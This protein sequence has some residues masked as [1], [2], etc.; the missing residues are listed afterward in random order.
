MD[1]HHDEPENIEL[2]LDEYEV[3]RPEFLAQTREPSFIFND[4][5]ISVNTACVRRLPDVEYVQLLINRKKQ[6]LAVRVSREE[7]IFSIPWAKTKDGK[8]F[9]RQITGRMFFMKVCDMMGWNPLHRHKILGKLCKANGE[10]IFAFNLKAVS[11]YERTIA[12]DGKR[13]TSRIPLLPAEWKDQFGIPY[14]EHKKALQI[15]M[16]DGFALFSLG[17]KQ[18]SE[19]GDQQSDGNDPNSRQPT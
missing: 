9:P 5:K 11:T 19:A 8:R 13:K 7:D 1:R 10:F 6:K 16:F 12:E 14:E 17:E 2:N 3:T 4:G 15:N 18:Q